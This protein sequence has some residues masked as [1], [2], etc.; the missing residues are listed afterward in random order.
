MI[1]AWEICPSLPVFQ[2]SREEKMLTGMRR[3]HCFPLK[4]AESTL[5]SPSLW[6]LSL[7][8]VNFTCVSWVL[9]PA[10]EDQI[11]LVCP[12]ETRKKCSDERILN[13]WKNWYLCKWL[14]PRKK[15]KPVV[16]HMH[17]Q[18]IQ[19]KNC[20]ELLYL[21]DIPTWTGIK[22]SVVKWESGRLAPHPLIL[23]KSF[24]INFPS[25]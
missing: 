20:M 21:N 25:D 4:L 14:S 24:K 10:S 16:W 1:K 23:V 3:N 18:Y 19:E 5:S 11:F 15:E 9:R 6:G 17:S 22:E 13:T 2:S 12:L 7:S 8:P